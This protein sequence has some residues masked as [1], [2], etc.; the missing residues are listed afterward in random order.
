MAES[1]FNFGLAFKVA[2]WMFAA[3]ILIVVGAG[4]LF[5]ELNKER[6]DRDLWQMYAALIVIGVFFLSIG[7][8]AFYL[9][10]R[11]GRQDRLPKS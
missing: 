4:G 11:E 2:K 5:K 10:W 8:G 1:L 7:I 9:A 6:P 3:G